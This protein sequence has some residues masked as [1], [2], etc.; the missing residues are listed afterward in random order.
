MVEALYWLSLDLRKNKNK[1]PG[2]AGGYL[3][4]NVSGSL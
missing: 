3:L 4:I 2:Y 1:T